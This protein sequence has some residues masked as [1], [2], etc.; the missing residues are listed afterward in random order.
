M[1]LLLVLALTVVL[2]ASMLEVWTAILMYWS[3]IVIYNTKLNN[4]CN[5]CCS[6]PLVRICRNTYVTISEGFLTDLTQNSSPSQKY[7]L[8]S[9]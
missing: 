9:L 3:Q 5:C 8:C 1:Y 6:N 4:V 7:V 2:K